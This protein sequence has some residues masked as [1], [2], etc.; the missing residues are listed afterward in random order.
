[1]SGCGRIAGEQT[2]RSGCVLAKRLDRLPTLKGQ[3]TRE[4][5]RG[6]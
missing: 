1:M 3:N 4:R 6:D 5:A 2:A